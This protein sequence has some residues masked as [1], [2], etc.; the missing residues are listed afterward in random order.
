MHDDRRTSLFLVDRPTPLVAAAL[1][2]LLPAAGAAAQ[3]DAAS[4]AASSGKT[5]QISWTHALGA[6]TNRLL[7][8]GVTV[9]D[10]PG[11]PAPP[12]VAADV[13]LDG[14]PL[15]PVEG[16]VAVSRGPGG[17]AWTQLFVLGQASLP[18]AGSYTVSVALPALVEGIAG[19]ATSFRGLAQSPPEAVRATVASHASRITTTRSPRVIAS[20]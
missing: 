16:G 8:V 2:A 6:G 13:R 5:R 19:G 17:V 20:T 1:L 10:R 18:P 7:V 12:Q 15:T 4:S 11:K 3:L 9:A 14:V